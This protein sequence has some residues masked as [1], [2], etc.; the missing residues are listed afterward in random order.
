LYAGLG[1]CLVGLPLLTWVLVGLRDSVQGESVLLL[2]LLAVVVVAV[3]GGAFP[4]LLAAFA[5]FVLANWFLTPPYYTLT[6]DE[7]GALTDLVVFVL[8]AA[9]VSI[10]VEVGARNR[11]S[12]ERNRLQTHMVAT[13]S[14]AEMRGV[15]VEQVLEQVRQVYGMR[16]VTL[17]P[18]AAPH[19]PVVTVG[20]E[21]AGGSPS[22]SPDGAGSSP[23]TSPALTAPATEAL[24]LFGY[25][26]AVF[27]ED[28]V[29]L[30]AL[31]G[32][33]G[34]AWESARLAR[35]AARAEQLAETDKVR[36]AL[37]TA[38]G[39]DLRTPLAGIKTAVSGLR[40]PDIRWGPG[41]QDELLGTIE[42]GTDRLAALVDN[43]LAMSRIQAGA[44]SVHTGQVDVEEVAS[45]A[46]L[47]LDAAGVDLDVPQ[48]LPPVTADAILLERVVAN[49]VANALRFSPPGERVTITATQPD[50]EP[51]TVELAVTDHG[52]G[53]DPQRW[54]EMFAPFQRLG[55]TT[56]GGLGLGLAIARGLTE[57]MGGTLAPTTTPG[58]G[59]TMTV[60]LPA[61]TSA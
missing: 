7:P 1:L 38:V 47:T 34:R 17:A 21:A 23:G 42:D 27:A 53:A 54:D 45:R 56:P 10:T 12:A 14:S 49:L 50:D 33:A 4:G 13:L 25:G 51:A 55:D 26:E 29:L 19:E 16:T 31:A 44:L 5:G 28:R 58:G 59:L 60:R 43:L 32:T 9:L 39:H 24:T 15:S 40:Q 8:A 61:E 37:L 48:A 52:P 36:S 57:A 11:A 18:H 41:E 2:Y 22:G 20:P 6:V 46:L 3:V 30:R 35:E